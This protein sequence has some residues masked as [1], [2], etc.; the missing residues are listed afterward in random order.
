MSVLSYL[1]KLP[2]LIQCE[3][4]AYEQALRAWL[5]NC[6]PPPLSAFSVAS[7]RADDPA[8]AH[9]TVLHEG[10]LWSGTTAVRER[11][12]W[13][14]RTERGVVACVNVCGAAGATSRLVPLTVRQQEALW[15]ARLAVVRRDPL[16]RNERVLANGQVVP[17]IPHDFVAR[18]EERAERNAT[19]REQRVTVAKSK[20]KSLN[21]ALWY[22]NVNA[23]PT[24]DE[25]AMT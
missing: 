8:L 2:N 19:R 25:M 7:D 3:Y 12:L 1:D 17:E 15:A 5:T 6:P 24:P 20:V 22:A 13:W 10:P 18:R 4:M 21:A 14:V 9:A 11:D 23:L 16:W